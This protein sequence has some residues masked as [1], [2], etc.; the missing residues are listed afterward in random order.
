MTSSI[1]DKFKLGDFYSKKT[2]SEIINEPNL[3]QVR[4]GLYYCKNS[5]S[6]FLFV[7]LVKVNKPE[8]FRFNDKFQGEYFH[9]DSQ[10]TQHINSPKIQEIINKEVEVFLFYREYP[11]VK[12]KTQPFIYCGI[13]DYLEF[14]KKTSKPVHMIF[15][16][17]DY[18]DE[19]SNDHLLNLYTWSPDKVG[20]ESSDLKD[21]SGKVSDR[22]KKNYKKTH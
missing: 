19:S 22:R 7:E 4:E 14:D 9:W 8:R 13:L 12:S 10:T 21:M 11:K 17:L 18:N 2:L 5:N 15:Q 16:S 3:K 1:K 6:T 20:R